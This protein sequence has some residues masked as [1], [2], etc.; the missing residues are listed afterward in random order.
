MVWEAE[1]REQHNTGLE[2]AIIFTVSSVQFTVKY[3]VNLDF[4]R[5][6]LSLLKR[7]KREKTFHWPKREHV[8]FRADI[9]GWS[10]AFLL[11]TKVDRYSLATRVLDTD[12]VASETGRKYKITDFILL[13]TFGVCSS[14]L[15]YPGMKWDLFH[16]QNKGDIIQR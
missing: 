4:W 12:P 2:K 14:Q 15:Y 5:R 16:T 9:L 7:K 11:E 13:F 6:A 3:Y 8:R 1:G 10:L